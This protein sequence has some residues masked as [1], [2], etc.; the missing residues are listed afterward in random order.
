HD[1]GS[2]VQQGQKAESNVDGPWRVVQKQKRGHKGGAAK[3]HA[4][5]EWQSTDSQGRVNAVPVKINVDPKISGSR[6]ISL[7][8]DVSVLNEEDMEREDQRVLFETHE[9]NISQPVETI[10]NV[11]N[12][13]ANKGGNN[14]ERI[15]K[16]TKL[17]TRGGG[18]GK[19]K[20]VSSVKKGIEN[21]CE[22]MGP[23]RIESSKMGEI[24]Q[25]SSHGNHMANT[26]EESH[27]VVMKEGM[28]ENGPEVN[29]VLGQKGVQNPNLSRPPNILVSPPGGISHN[30]KVMGD[31]VLEGELFMDADDQASM[32]S[33]ESDME[34]V[35]E[36][37]RL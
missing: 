31:M 30:S 24:Y 26:N 36:T 23:K 8:D 29:L 33:M 28:K 32:G 37:P 4:T 16:D 2:N 15:S 12:R 1:E 19:G 21:I 20:V 35:A 10:Q 11:K 14:Q 6:F 5:A 27:V 13:R 9:G 17:V 7:S 18:I 25:Q 3:A 22:M 34:I